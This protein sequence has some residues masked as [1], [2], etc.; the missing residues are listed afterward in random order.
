VTHPAV[1][2]LAPPER[3]E[4]NAIP[5]LPTPLLHTRRFVRIPVPTTAFPQ[6]VHVFNSA[7]LVGVVEGG[8]V[9]GGREEGVGGG[10]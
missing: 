3:T 5:K 8:E 7:V 6:V 4:R 2:A 1:V 9:P 10:D